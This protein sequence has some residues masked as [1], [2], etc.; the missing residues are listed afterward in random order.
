MATLK[1]YDTHNMIAYLNKTKGSEGFHQIVD[2]LNSSHIKF[3]LTVNPTIYTLL[4]QHFWQIAIANTLDTQEI[5]ITTTIDGN[6][7][8]ISEAS[9]RRHLKLENSDGIST[10]PNTKIFKQLTLMGHMIGS[11]CYFTNYEDYDGGFVSFG[12][13]EGRISGNGI[14]REFSVAMTPQ[15]NGVAEKKNKT[16]I[17]AARTMYSVVRKAMRVFNKRTR[18][19]EETLNIRFLK[20]SPN[21]K[22]NGPDWLFDI[23]S[24]ILSMNYE[25]VVARKQTKGIAGTKYNIVT[26]P[27]DSAVDAGKKATEV[28]ESRVSDNGGQD[29]LVTKSEFE[30]LLQQERQ[31]KHIN[32]TNSFNTVSSPVSTAGP[33][34][35]NTALPSPINNAGTPASVEEEVDMN[36]VVSSYTIPNAPLTKFLKDHPKDQPISSIETPAIGTKL[37]F[38]NKKDE[39]G[40]VVK[41]KARLVAQGDTQEEGIDYD[42]VF[43]Q[44]ARI[45]ASRLLLAYASFKDF[46]VY[47]I[48]V[49][50]DFLYGKI[51]EEVYVCQPPGFED[52]N[53]P[54]KIYKVNQKE[55]SAEFEKLM[56]DKFQMSSMEELSFFLGL[57]VQQK[58]DGIF[59]SQDKYLADILK[60]FDFSTMKTSS[61]PIDPNKALDKDAEDEDVDV[62][63]NRS[64]ISSL[65]YLTITRSDITFVV[66]ACAR[67]Q[68][69]PKTSHLHDVKR[70]FRYL[71]SQPKLGLWYPR[72]SPFDLEAYSDSDYARASL[73]RKSTTREYV[74]ATNCCGPVLWIQNQMID[75]GFYFL[76]T[77]I[78]IDN[79]R[80]DGRCFMDKFKVKA[81]ATVSL[82]H[83]K[84]FINPLSPINL[85]EN[86]RVKDQ[87]FQLSP[88]KHPQSRAVGTGR[89]GISTASRIIST[90]KET[91]ST[92]GVSI[93]VSTA[94]MVQESTSSP[95]AT[96]DKEIKD[97]FEVTMRRIQ[98]F[99]PMEKEDDKEVSKLAG[100]RGS[101]RDAEEELDQGSSKKQ[102]TDEALGSVEEQPV[103]EQKELSQKDLKQLTIIAP[104]QGMNV[105]ALQV[106]NLIID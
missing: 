96:N 34:F 43:V 81:V 40:I 83:F 26:G 2:F 67:F 87:Q 46:V 36:N 84:S 57:Q 64:M 68:V 16:L 5:Q 62:H 77:K 25:L 61:T 29:D 14:K 31:T 28:D 80:K 97:L 91:V 44:V 24:L 50:S 63:L 9:I 20:N 60:K 10:L 90:T 92:A 88:I 89:D 1:F 105:E 55:L 99:V 41:N 71:K 6:V 15:Q 69:T 19:V 94:G 59:I 53:F 12:D 35:A 8:L 101:K 100:D 51:K 42:E 76:N 23:D 45:E 3:A 103:E 79:E 38:R 30:R 33:S 104:E 93:L 70:I 7:K 54:D 65:M 11:K 37:V 66:C 82:S 47:Q 85:G 56:R 4:I 52:P 86:E 98:D 49:K 17:E 73:D 78:Y 32:N 72:D 48:D 22:G 27:K 102:K 13:G 95:R 21:V 106:K 39:K 18:I 75:Y 58:C 74:A